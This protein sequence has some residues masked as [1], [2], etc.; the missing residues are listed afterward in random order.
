MDRRVVVLNTSHSGSLVMVQ[1]YWLSYDTNDSTHIR[2][3][4][5]QISALGFRIL[6]MD[7]DYS[8]WI[9]NYRVNLSPILSLFVDVVNTTITRFYKFYVLC[10]VKGANEKDFTL[11]LAIP[12]KAISYDLNSKTLNEL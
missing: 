11:V 10:V 4:I 5:Y 7:R 2:F 8:S 6:Q 1:Y 12:G 3:E 9:V